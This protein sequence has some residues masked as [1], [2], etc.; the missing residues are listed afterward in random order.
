MSGP[1][2]ITDQDRLYSAAI[3]D[4]GPAIARL[5]TGYE[6]N[7]EQRRDLQQEIHLALWTSFANFDGRCSIKTWVYR[8]GHNVAISHVVKDKRHNDRIQL[9]IDELAEEPQQSDSL[10]GVD[11]HNALDRLRVLIQSL[12]A[13]DRQ[14]ILLYLDDLDAATIAQ[15]TGMS[16]SNVATKIHRI[17]HILARNFASRG[18]VT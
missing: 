13:P 3:A 9:G 5:V 2:H 17:K 18:P 4:F 12:R 14:L 7:R 11:A 10:E 16:P 15:I 8:V 6:N 1:S